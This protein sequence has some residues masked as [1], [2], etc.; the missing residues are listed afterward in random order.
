MYKLSCSVTHVTAAFLQ[1]WKRILNCQL[2]LTDV[3]RTISM[4]K[5]A[6]V[7]ISHQLRHHLS[8]SQTGMDRSCHT[9][10]V[11]SKFNTHVQSSCSHCFSTR[12]GVVYNHWTGLVD[13]TSGLHWW[14]GLKCLLKNSPVELHLET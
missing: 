7:N 2:S 14:T 8:V 12:S 9:C 3:L 1:L 6:A 5:A 13:W 11:E 10:L 4:F